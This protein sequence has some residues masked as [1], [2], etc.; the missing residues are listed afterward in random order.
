MFWR[1]E[2]VDTA[3][4]LEADHFCTGQFDELVGLNKF[5][6]AVCREI[7]CYSTCFVVRDPAPTFRRQILGVGVNTP[8]AIQAVRPV[9][10]GQQRRGFLLHLKGRAAAPVVMCEHRCGYIVPHVAEQPRLVHAV[11][12]Q[13]QFITRV[14]NVRCTREQVAQVSSGRHADQF[15]FC[16]YLDHLY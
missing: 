6:G 4:C 5:N 11:I 14:G 2:L 9:A 7:L 3:C 1:Q 8:H 12:D 13:H 15:M 16:G 10:Q